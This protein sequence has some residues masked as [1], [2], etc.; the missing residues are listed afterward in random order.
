MR[1]GRGRGHQIALLGQ[2]QRAPQRPA[3]G[4]GLH[5]AFGETGLAAATR[6]LR[7]RDAENVLRISTMDFVAY[8]LL[9]PRLPALRERFPQLELRV[10]T[11]TGLVDLHGGEFD[12]AL[13]LGGGPWQDITSIALAPLDCAVV[14]S[15]QRARSIRSEADLLAHPLIELRGQEPRGWHAYVKRLGPAGKQARITTLETY[16][17]TVCAAEQGIGL[18]FGL[19]PLTSKWVLDGR[20]AVITE[21]REPLPGGAQFVF[22]DGDTRPELPALADWLRAQFAELPALP[23]GRPTRKSGARPSPRRATRA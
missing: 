19:F 23:A 14:C 17:E 18:A 9:I 21:R 10:E 15:P 22:R 11:S 7:R 20:L 12:A 6:R 16:F 1:P 4:Q 5:R 8:E 13:R 3:C 2:P